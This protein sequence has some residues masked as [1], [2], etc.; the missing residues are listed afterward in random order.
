MGSPVCQPCEGRMC[1]GGR[2]REFGCLKWDLLSEDEDVSRTQ[3]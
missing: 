1:E 3:V 2:L